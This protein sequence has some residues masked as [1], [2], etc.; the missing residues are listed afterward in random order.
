MIQG[1]ID[2]SKKNIVSDFAEE[3]CSLLLVSKGSRTLTRYLKDK[4]L[5]IWDNVEQAIV[6]MPYFIIIETLDFFKSV[7]YFTR[8]YM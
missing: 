5:Q 2:I 3:E 1:N 7:N 6:F 8:K 4:T